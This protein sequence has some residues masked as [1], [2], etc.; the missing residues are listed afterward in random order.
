MEG[1]SSLVRAQAF[2]RLYVALTRARRGLLVLEEQKDLSLSVLPQAD[3]AWWQ[4]WEAA[5]T[6]W[7]AVSGGGGKRKV[8]FGGDDRVEDCRPCG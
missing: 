3:S 5:S 8:S 7:C 4:S 1:R 2:S 6:C